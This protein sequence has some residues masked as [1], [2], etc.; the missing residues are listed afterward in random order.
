MNRSLLFVVTLLSSGCATVQQAQSPWP[1]DPMYDAPP[2]AASPEVDEWGQHRFSDTNVYRGNKPERRGDHVVVY[3]SHAVN[4][5]SRAKTT[6]GRESSGSAEVTAFF[7][8]ETA[9]PQLTPGF[10]PS[11]SV[12][13]TDSNSYSGQGSTDR[14]GA[15]Q[16]VVTAKVLD[17]QANGYLIIGARQQVKINNEVDILWLYGVVD[18]RLIGSDNSISSRNVGDLR[19]EYTGLGVVAGKQRP[20]WLTRVLDVIRPM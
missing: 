16:T 20:G 4:G 17:V 9:I 15:L 7:G 3:V 13:G 10:K 18:P 14:M 11:A 5:D 6:V 19:M 8:L 2:P 12:G 1:A